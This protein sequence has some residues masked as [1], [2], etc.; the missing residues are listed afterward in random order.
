MI[1]KELWLQS[2]W[3]DISFDRSPLNKKVLTS[4][5]CILWSCIVAMASIVW[6]DFIRAIKEKV[7]KN[8]NLI[9]L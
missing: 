9:L 8:L 6:I 3:N 1:S 4:I 2:Y 7:E 5:W